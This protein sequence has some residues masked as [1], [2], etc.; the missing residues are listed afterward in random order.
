MRTR[1]K[2]N[3]QQRMELCADLLITE[4]QALKHVNQEGKPV[5][6]EIGCG[7]GTF[8]LEMAKRHEDCFFIAVERVFDVALLAA[9]KL[10]AAKVDNVRLIVS[11]VEKLT[12]WIEEGS[13]EHIYLN[14]SDPWPK[15][16]HAK[17]RLTHRDYLT[18]YKKWLSPDGMIIFK[19]DNRPL[20]DFSLEEFQ[21]NGFVLQDITYDLHNSVWETE[22]IHTEYEDTFSKKGFTINRVV[23]KLK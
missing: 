13:I 5:Y 14:F 3:G 21:A 17:R 20:F 22:N 1:K 6:L 12:E 18:L 16:R 7:K 11:S 23:A 10:K 8:I 15:S 19:T 2:K 4:P 9:E